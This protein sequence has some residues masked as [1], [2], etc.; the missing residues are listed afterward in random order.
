MWSFF[1]ENATDQ[2]MIIS[3]LAKSRLRQKKMRQIFS[4]RDNTEKHAWKLVP[5]VQLMLQKLTRQ[6]TIYCS[7]LRKFIYFC[8]PRLSVLCN[9]KRLQS[10]IYWPAMLTC[11][12]KGVW[13]HF[14]IGTGFHMGNGSPG[15]NYGTLLCKLKVLDRLRTMM[16][17]LIS[18]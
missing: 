4:L 15:L 6:C 8:C 18:I 2:Q 11:N 1:P 14:S 3:E 9:T 10:C 17:K 12:L 16:W 7:A 5:V 13:R